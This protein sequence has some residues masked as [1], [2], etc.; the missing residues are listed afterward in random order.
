MKDENLAVFVDA[1]ANYFETT[2]DASANIGTPFLIKNI[3]EYLDDF[4]GIIGITGNHKGS[5][6]YTT[7]KRMAI[8]L[9]SSMGLMTTKDSK[10]MDLVGEVCNT[11]SG[12]A[13]REFGE[14]FMLSVPLVLQGKGSDIAVSNVASIYVI[15]IVWNDSKSHLIINLEES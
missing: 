5:V 13:R 7:P 8:Q 2:T 12:N 1:L 6:F 9:I 4:T 10:L 14:D 3:N 11:I 15:P